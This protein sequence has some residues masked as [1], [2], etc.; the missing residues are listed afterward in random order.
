[1]KL[2]ER[3]NKFESKI[4]EL[5]REVETLQKSNESMKAEISVKSKVQIQNLE[6]ENFDLKSQIEELE[7]SLKNRDDDLKAALNMKEKEEALTN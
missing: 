4:A 1:L 2:T 5:T 3:T 6:T 7:K